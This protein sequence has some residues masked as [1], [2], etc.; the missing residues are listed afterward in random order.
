M[1]EGLVK[2]MREKGGRRPRSEFLGLHDP[3]ADT[4][5]DSPPAPRSSGPLLT[6]EKFAELLRAGTS[7]V[8]IVV[9][10]ALVVAALG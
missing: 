7:L 1:D 2:P 5:N 3:Y 8:V 4:D 10:M 9:L 6:R